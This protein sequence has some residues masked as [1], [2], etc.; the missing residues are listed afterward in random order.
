ML[1][2]LKRLEERSRLL[3]S[4]Q[5]VPVIEGMRTRPNLHG[6]NKP[7]IIYW[8]SIDMVSIRRKSGSRR[9]KRNG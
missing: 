4:G 3:L 5:S 6:I 1:E 9:S 7:G 2:G 8:K